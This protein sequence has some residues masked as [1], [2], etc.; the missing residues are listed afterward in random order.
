MYVSSKAT[1]TEVN[2]VHCTPE[3]LPENVFRNLSPKTE[4]GRKL[5]SKGGWI[6][7]YGAYLND[8]GSF[9]SAGDEKVNNNVVLANAS[10]TA[11]TSK[12]SIHHSVSGRQSQLLPWLK[13]GDSEKRHVE[14]CPRETCGLS[15]A[16]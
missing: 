6:A 15:G 5:L 4:A 3:G 11:N 13:S 2:L 7:A 14:I 1:L 16:Q 10:L 12:E 9:R 8:D